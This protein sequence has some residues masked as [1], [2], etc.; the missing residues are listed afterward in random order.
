M[1]VLNEVHEV[2]CWFI[3]WETKDW[4]QLQAHLGDYSRKTFKIL[5]N[6]SVSLVVNRGIAMK[7]FPPLCTNDAEIKIKKACW[8]NG[9]NFLKITRWTK[10]MRNLRFWA[11]SPLIVFFHFQHVYMTHKIDVH[12]ELQH[13]IE[14]R[15]STLDSNRIHRSVKMRLHHLSRI[16]CV[17]ESFRLFQVVNLSSPE[18]LN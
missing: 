18:Y 7:L 11:F 16:I 12:A 4:S 5:F 10:T 3:A 1:G 13:L 17:F 8:S 14:I 9:L 2:P 6:F 15:I